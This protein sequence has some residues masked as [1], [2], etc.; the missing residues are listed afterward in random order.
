MVVSS[1]RA[2]RIRGF[3][4]VELL[5]VISIIALMVALLLP[6]LSMAKR[7]G[8]QIQ[9]GS[10]QRQIMVAFSGYAVDL[11]DFI[12]PTTSWDEDLGAAGY[13]GTG[14]WYGPWVS[15]WGHRTLRWQIFKCPGETPAVII[16]GNTDYTW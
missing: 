4:L 13:V 6:A 14:A 16:N 7:V 9:C 15:A 3:T 2:E 10:N 5:V 8:Y 1:R 11:S 12:P